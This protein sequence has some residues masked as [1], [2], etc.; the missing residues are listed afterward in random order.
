MLLAEARGAGSPLV[1]AGDAPNLPTLRAWVEQTPL[2]RGLERDALEL[3]NIALHEACTNVLEH[4][5]HGDPTQ[6]LEIGVPATANPPGRPRPAAQASAYLLIRDQASPFR[7]GPMARHRLLGSAGA[8]AVAASGSTSS[9][10][11]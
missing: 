4:G 9:I 6:R 7:P 3:M 5:Y 1:L 8:S 11:A 2:A 10:A